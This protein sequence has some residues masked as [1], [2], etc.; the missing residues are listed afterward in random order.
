MLATAPVCI[1]S[2]PL[3][4]IKDSV[5]GP[6]TR[7]ERE[8]EFHPLDPHFE[9]P[10][11]WQVSKLRQASTKVST[12]EVPR[13]SWFVTPLPSTASLKDQ[14]IAK[15]LLLVCLRKAGHFVVWHEF[16]NRT[17]PVMAG[18][19][20]KGAGSPASPGGTTH[21]NTHFVTGFGFCPT[22]NSG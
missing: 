17:I 13:M 15:S 6:G 21:L 9:Y 14:I 11:I 2:F 18:C 19:L 22:P 7:A 8:C 5:A 1:W 3:C 10:P 20:G 12:F 16:N 4:Y